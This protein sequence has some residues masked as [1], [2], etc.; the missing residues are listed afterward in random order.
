M[1]SD[2]LERRI[3][4]NSNTQVIIK[5]K[6]RPDAD[7]FRNTISLVHETSDLEPLQ[8]ATREELEATIRSIDL[9]NEQQEL[10]F[11]GKN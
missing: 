8:F 7:I 11:G 5:S 1:K 9:D 10:M 6:K 3:K 4:L 2:Y